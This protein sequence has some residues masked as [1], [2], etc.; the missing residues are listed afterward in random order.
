MTTAALAP[1]LLTASEMSGSAIAWS[2]VAAGVLIVVNGLFVAWE[3]AVLAARRASLQAGAE[4]GNRRDQAAVAA[5][6][7]V[8][9]QLAGAQLGITMAS[10]GLGFV[11]EPAI[12][13]LLEPLLGD[14]VSHDVATVLS[15]VIALAIVTF[16][17]LVVGEMVPKN[18]AIAS[19]EP[20]VRLLV[21]PYQGYLVIFRPFVRLLNG[22]ANLGCRAIGVEPRDEL[23]SGRS[24]AELTAIVRESSAEGAIADDDAQVLYGALEF[25][26]RAVGEVARPLSTVG[27]VRAGATAAQVETVARERHQVRVLVRDAGGVL[28]GYVHAKD[29]LALEGGQRF[30]PVP[31][32]AIRRMA[33]VRQEQSMVA[34]LRTM[35]RLGRHMAVV[36]DDEGRSVGV[37]SL[38]ETIRALIPAGLTAEP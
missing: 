14:L 17:H 32:E 31:T 27:V 20:T 11:G 21:L 28:L 25:A 34:V 18:V 30:A 8:S 5:L 9:I 26:E 29:L 4:A 2:L 1:V 6:S 22:L 35:R 23:G 12:A 10:L 3:F 13:G 36:L 7:D 38:D 16:L 37:I 33:R 19:P 15:F 24:V